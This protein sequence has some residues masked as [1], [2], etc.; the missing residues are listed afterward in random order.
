M[1]AVEI[2]IHALQPE[3]VEAEGLRMRRLTPEEVH[4]RVLDRRAGWLAWELGSPEHDDRIAEIAD[5]LDADPDLAAALEPRELDESRI[6]IV[7]D[8]ELRG[9]LR[10]AL[11][12]CPPSP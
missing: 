5:A 10:C 12:P 9:R 7:V 1:N 6:G 4:Q 2:W 11:D 8:D 3:P